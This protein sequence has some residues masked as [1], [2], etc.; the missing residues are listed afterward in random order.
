VAGL[1]YLSNKLGRGAQEEEHDE[2]D[3]FWEDCT[4]KNEKR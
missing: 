3:N 1:K 4:L 2:E